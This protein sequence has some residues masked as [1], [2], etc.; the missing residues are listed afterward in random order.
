MT[1]GFNFDIIVFGYFTVRFK[2][3]VEQLNILI[4]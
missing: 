1:G 3:E 4:I 2:D